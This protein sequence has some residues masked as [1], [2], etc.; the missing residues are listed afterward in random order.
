MRLHRCIRGARTIVG[1]KRMNCAPVVCNKL[2]APGQQ[3]RNAIR[4]DILQIALMLSVINDI[5]GRSYVSSE[6]V[7]TWSITNALMVRCSL[8]HEVKVLEQFDV[9]LGM[10]VLNNWP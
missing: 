3:L 7:V 4:H 6:G 1:L 9:Q 5:G 10:P 8:C 2:K